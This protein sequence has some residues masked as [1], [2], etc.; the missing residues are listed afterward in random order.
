MTRC[1]LLCGK[2]NSG[3]F[4]RRRSSFLPVWSCDCGFSLPLHIFS[5][6]HS[7]CPWRWWTQA[8]ASQCCCCH[9]LMVRRQLGR[10]SLQ[11]AEAMA[12]DSCECGLPY[13][14]PLLMYGR[15][16][17]DSPFKWQN[18]NYPIPYAQ[19]SQNLASLTHFCPYQLAYPT[20]FSH[21]V[22]HS[23]STSASYTRFPFSIATDSSFLLAWG[24]VLISMGTGMGETNPH[25]SLHQEGPINKA[26]NIKILTLHWVLLVPL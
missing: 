12:A 19:C 25:F 17:W 15:G 14:P 5:S 7:C 20:P 3:N 18:N 16:T 23:S 6:T 1:S 24:L 13:P 26:F 9:L 4:R 2:E 10:V 8:A 11:V 22:P 21:I